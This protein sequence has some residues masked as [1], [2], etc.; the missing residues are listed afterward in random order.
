MACMLR[1]RQRQYFSRKA[2][3]N[4]CVQSARLAVGNVGTKHGDQEFGRAD[5]ES[6][7]RGAG[8]PFG[9]GVNAAVGTWMAGDGGH[10]MGV[11]APG[12]AP[13]SAAIPH[14]LPTEIPVAG[15]CALIIF[16]YR[17]V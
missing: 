17:F 11:V 6:F 5:K 8:V 12:D 1:E 7:G 10:G 3:P 15:I 9:L 14:C 2:E 4:R 16:K 13:G